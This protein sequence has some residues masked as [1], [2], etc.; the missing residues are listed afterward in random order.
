MEKIKV[1]DRN[2]F[3]VAAQ[4][5]E[6]V[7]SEP[8]FYSENTRKPFFYDFQLPGGVWVECIRINNDLNEFVIN[9]SEQ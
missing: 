7:A 1:I 2:G 9:L 8:I 5:R 4:V 6:A 3:P